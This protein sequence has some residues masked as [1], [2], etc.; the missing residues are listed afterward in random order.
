MLESRPFASRESSDVAKNDIGFL[1][2]ALYLD[3]AGAEPYLA[4]GL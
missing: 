3:P 1:R 2:G 4:C